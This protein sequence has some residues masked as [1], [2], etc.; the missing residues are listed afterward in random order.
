MAILLIS[1]GF[2]SVIAQALLVRELAA[3]FYGNEALL[4]LV[5]AVWLAA[6]AL[7]ASWLRPERF[8]SPSLPPERAVRWVAPL[9][10]VILPA[11]MAA[12]RQLPLWLSVPGGMAAPLWMALATAATLLPLCLLLGGMFALAA[13]TPRAYLCESLGAVAGGTLFSLGLAHWLNPFTLALELGALNLAV[14]VGGWS[15]LLRDGRF[16]GALLLLLAAF[17][18][19]S[20]LQAATLR[21]QYGPDL[22]YSADSPYGRLAVLQRGEQRVFYQNGQLSFETQSVAAE[23]VVHLPLLAYPAWSTPGAQPTGRVP[24]RVLL[25]GGAVNGDLAPLLQYPL[26]Q[27]VVVEPDAA[28][29]AAARRTLP[30]ALLAPLDDPR[31][32]VATDDGRRYVQR[33]RESFDVVILDL[34]EPATGALNRFYTAEF[35]AEVQSCLAADGIL[36]LR[37]PSAENYWNPDLLRRNASVYNALCLAFEHVLV[38]PGE[39]DTYLASHFP[40][41]TDPA[42][43]EE[44]LARRGVR[45]VLVTPAYLEDLLTGDRLAQ[46]Q[47]AL[48]TPSAART[49]RDLTPVSAYYHLSLWL[50]RFSP[51][52]HSLWG[53]LENVR[54]WW[55]AIPLAVLVGAA[56][57]RRRGA[58][59][60]VVG[61]AGW[62]GMLTNLAVMAAFQAQH[63]TLYRDVGLMTAVFLGGHALGLWLGE[64][65][66]ELRNGLLFLLLGGALGAGALAWALSLAPLS[67]VFWGLALLGGALTGSVYPAACARSSD[68]PAHRPQT[69]AIR[70]L[71]AADLLG[72]CLGALLGGALLLPLLGIPQSCLAASLSL[73]AASAI[74]Y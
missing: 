15:R 41:A 72:G 63:G 37:L 68:P 29:I 22:V 35:F 66:R 57:L 34:P 36:S 14:A 74:S 73:L 18:A 53:A 62:S 23:E 13:R 7:G 65:V 48:A 51:R 40:L 58:W 54:W 27:V 17:P 28:L 6:V 39:T 70:A 11:Q 10:A 60:W 4:G 61:L 69:Q 25:L 56:R 30:A 20:W 49:N 1:L 64:W 32:S 50:S 19:G 12:I 21:A 42:V 44:R 43:W 52:L 24:E 16:W 5:L 59:P 67:P 33:S 3:V 2:T 8:R 46:A 26:K 9:L 31:V 71:Y 45:T 55:M 47:S 38:L